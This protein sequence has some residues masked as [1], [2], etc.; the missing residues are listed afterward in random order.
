ML[1][2]PAQSTCYVLKTKKTR[3]GLRSAYRGRC[4]QQL[5]IDFINLFGRRINEDDI[6]PIE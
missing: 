5:Q 2:V 1:G 3:Q 4:A 6:S